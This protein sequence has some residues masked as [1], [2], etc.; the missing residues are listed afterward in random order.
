[1]EEMT[2]FYELVI[3]SPGPIVKTPPSDGLT[4]EVILGR[5]L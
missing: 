3:S 1:M 4:E 5:L 2:H